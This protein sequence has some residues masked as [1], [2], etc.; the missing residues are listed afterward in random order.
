MNGSLSTGRYP[1]G[2]TIGPLL[3]IGF[4]GFFGFG[5][6]LG[7]LLFF[8]TLARPL[9]TGLPRALLAT[10]FL[11]GRLLFNFPMRVPSCSLLVASGAQKAIPGAN[12]VPV[13]K[14]LFFQV[15]PSLSHCNKTEQP[16]MLKDSAAHDRISTILGSSMAY[17][18]FTVNSS[19]SGILRALDGLRGI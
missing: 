1:L 2:R 10:A 14:P 4:I 5:A 6:G 16:Q 8:A 7:A 13:F 18:T 17:R 9:V 12:M 15:K 19:P 11:A 3:V